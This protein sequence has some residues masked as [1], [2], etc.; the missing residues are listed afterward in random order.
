MDKDDNYKLYGWGF[1]KY[2]QTGSLDFE[3]TTY[4]I[5]IKNGTENDTLDLKN[6]YE[7]KFIIDSFIV[8]GNESTGIRNEFLKFITHPVT[9]PGSSTS[10]AESLNVAV[11][12]GI[13]LLTR[14]VIAR[15]TSSMRTNL[16]M[17]DMQNLKAAQTKF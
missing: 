11:A 8:G 17:Q 14:A 5:E 12:I 10:A 6:I 13:V 16:K 15:R 3:L 7:E 9:I 2:G 4:P 1:S